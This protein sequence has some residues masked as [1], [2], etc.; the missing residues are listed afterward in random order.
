MQN[1]NS[2]NILNL[3]SNEAIDFFMRADQYHGFELPEYFV[4]DDL[5]ES[6]KNTIADRPYEEC[7]AMGK[8]P[9]DI[10]DV[11]LDILLNKDGRYAVRPI[12]LPN[13]FLYYFM[14]RE[15]CDATGWA[16]VKDLFE[17]FS[18]PHITSCALPVIATKKEAFHKSATIL[19]W[20][21]A[22]E[23]RSVELSLEYHYMFVT[24]I[25]NCYGSINPQ[26]FDWAFDLKNTKYERKSDFPIA[27]NVQKYLRAFQQGRNI[28]IP[29]GSAI[30]DFASEIILGYSDLL[31]H[32]AIDREGIDVQYEI[33]RYR[34]DYR[35]F[36]NDKGALE[37]ISYILQHVLE[38]LN[39]RMNSKKTKISES[40]V[41]D[42]IKPDK[43]FYIYNT[44]IF[45]KKGV[46]FDS[47]EK[48]LLY[49]LMFAR[50]YPDS[51]SIRTML[52]DIDKR[53]AE[54]LKPYEVE[55]LWFSLDSGKNEITKIKRQRLLT[56]GSV[57]AMSAVCTQIALE[58]VGCCHYALR[59]LSRMV[60]SLKD[61]DEK[62]DIIDKVYEKLCHQPNS[63]Y[64][65]LWLQNITYLRDKKN[66]SSPYTMRLCRLAAGDKVEL[67]NNEWLKKEYRKCITSNSVIDKNSLKKLSPIITFREARAYDDMVAN[68]VKEGK[69]KKKKVVRKPQA[70][71]KTV[72]ATPSAPTGAAVTYRE[73]FE[74]FLDE[75]ALSKNS[76]QRVINKFDNIYTDQDIE[77]FKEMFG[78]KWESELDKFKR[79]FYDH[80]TKIDPN[81]QYLLKTT[82]TRLNVSESVI[83]KLVE[84]IRK[85]HDI[86]GDSVISSKPQATAKTVAATPSAP[87]DGAV[88]YRE[89]FEKFLDED[90]LSKNSLQRVINK[91]DNIYTDQD[92]EGFKEMFGD[93]WESELDKFK[94]EFY[95]HQTKIDPNGQYLLKTTLTR[96]NVSESVIEK[97]V[98][99]IRKNHDLKGDDGVSLCRI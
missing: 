85:N 98:E 90:A 32:E 57:R 47:F 6:V 76:L 16:I 66:G 4:F 96:L 48:H 25:T 10:V 82:L 64:N 50:Q 72:A 26:A 78:D 53:I 75:D 79:E 22:M 27:K 43:L 54:H 39:F 30:F 68:E 17:K 24:D 13:P 14:V 44:P 81:G 45:N 86:K 38:G 55:E 19:N 56:G 77:G 62:M 70:T 49:I 61:E 29:Q 8:L 83:E 42:S 7:L 46:D 28:G 52:S 60:D 94:R 71:A 18:V 23:Q 59:V 41:T 93:K 69:H 91:F 15:L 12:V 1:K 99:A 80:Q 37:R 65:Q 35:I 36:C 9:D 63:T 11:N 5:L 51:G 74:K 58:N 88:T 92:I 73:I 2:Q 95:D 84:A 33:I 34:D 31:L 67:W 3:N 97:L 21:N 87:T 89:I 20:W 40:I